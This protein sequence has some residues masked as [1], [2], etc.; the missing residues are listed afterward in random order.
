MK[1]SLRILLALFIVQLAMPMAPARAED[2]NTQRLVV[3]LKNGQKV[4]H[5]L[6]DEPET[7]FNNGMLMLSTAKVSI[8]YPIADVVRYTYEGTMTAI[9]APKVKPGEVRFSQ[10]NDQMAFDGLTPGTQMQLYAP[11][12][13]LLRTQKAETGKTAVV[14]LKGLPSGLYVVKIGDASYKFMK[15]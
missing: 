14:S 8:S 12:G 9:N 13:K 15:K 7:R 6:T 4:Y 5:D 1:H 2:T 11:D 10:G 3:W